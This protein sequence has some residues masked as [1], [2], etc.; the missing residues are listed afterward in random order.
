MYYVISL[1]NIC[2]WY[3]H[4]TYLYKRYICIMLFPYSIPVFGITISR[5]CTK[6]IY[7]LCY[8][9]IQYLYLVSPYHVPVQKV[10]MYYVIS[11]FNICIWYHHIMYLYKRYICIMLFPYSI[12]VFGI[13]TSRT[14]IIGIYLLCYTCRWGRSVIRR[15]TRW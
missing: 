10:Y 3:H 15:I 8:F 14:C 1:F 13:T 2:I 4:I 6:G 12:S 11:L 5:T 9:P 7:V